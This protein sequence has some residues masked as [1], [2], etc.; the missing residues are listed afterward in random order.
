MKAQWRP[1]GDKAAYRPYLA[2]HPGG[3]IKKEPE[4]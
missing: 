4:Y 2:D 3:A 1:D